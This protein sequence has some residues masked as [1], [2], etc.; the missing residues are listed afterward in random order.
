MA[1]H[2]M[3]YTASIALAGSPL[4]APG[5]IVRNDLETQSVMGHVKRY[6]GT[7]GRVAPYAT[8]GL[9]WVSIDTNV[10]TGP[11]VGYCWF[12]PWWGFVCDSVQPTRTTTEL[13]TALGLGVRWD[14]SRRVF[15]DA[16]V[17]REWIDFDNASRPDFTQ[18][19]IAFGFHQ[20]DQARA[21]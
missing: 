17:G 12:D 15:L 16:S 21:R 5:Q 2:D 7:F 14:F 10:P 11:P 9:G 1:M 6:F 4:G 8:A 3:D 19:R 18:L 13:G 20:G